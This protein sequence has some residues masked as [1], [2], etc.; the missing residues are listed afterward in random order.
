MTQRL[1]LCPLDHRM[2]RSGS[3]R[4]DPNNDDHVI[5]LDAREHPKI[6]KATVTGL[7]WQ[8]RLGVP[9]RYVSYS[10]QLSAE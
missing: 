6:V 9:H 1:E 4:R 7:P 8:A 10:V 2:A 5:I 3:V